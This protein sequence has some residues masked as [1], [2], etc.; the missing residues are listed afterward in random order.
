MKVGIEIRIDVTKI[1]K[2]RIYQGKKGKYLTMTSFVDLDQ[3]DQ[4]GNNGFVSHKKEQG[5][6]ENTPILGNTKVCWKDEE[7]T[8]RSGAPEPSQPV[9]DDTIPF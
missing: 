4:Y 9:D 1:D 5:E 2:A 3:E 6:T 7:A 8:Q